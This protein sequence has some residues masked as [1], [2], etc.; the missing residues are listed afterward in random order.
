M[1]EYGDFS[2]FYFPVFG[3]LRK[4]GTGKKSVFGHFSRIMDNVYSANLTAV[5]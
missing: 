1:S 5:E 3:L 4:I 2:S